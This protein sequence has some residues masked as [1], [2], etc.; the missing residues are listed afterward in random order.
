M[1]IQKTA[2]CKEALAFQMYKKRKKSTNIKEKN[3]NNEEEES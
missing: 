1:Y 2:K 3:T